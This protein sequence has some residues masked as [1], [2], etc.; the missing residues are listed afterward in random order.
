MI[1]VSATTLVPSLAAL[2]SLKR[3]GVLDA[4]VTEYELERQ[5][6]AQHLECPQQHV[7]VVL[8]PASAAVSADELA[9]AGEFHIRA[10]LEAIHVIATDPAPPVTWRELAPTHVGVSRH[11]TDTWLW[12]GGDAAAEILTPELVRRRI[13]P[14]HPTHEGAPVVDAVVL[15]IGVDVRALLRD[16]AALCDVVDVDRNGRPFPPV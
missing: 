2:A 8:S 6:V 14:A 13:P 4:L 9:R 7:H 1:D 3:T 16:V 11:G 12:V 15:P 5:V 10:R